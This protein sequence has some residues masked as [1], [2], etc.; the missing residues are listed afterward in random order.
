LKKR[1]PGD[2]QTR[3]DE[4]LS[5]IRDLERAIAVLP[6]EYRRVDPPD[7]DGDMKDWPRIAK[8]QSDLLVQALATR[9]TRVA[10]YML[11][12]CQSISR[13]PWLGYTAARHH[14]YT[15][16][17]G[18]TAGADG[19]EGQRVL[20]DICRWHVEEFAYL[21]SRLESVPEGDGT[22]F[23]HTSLIYVHEHAEANPHK[24]QGLAMIVAG[25]SPKLAR[26]SYTKVE[27]T[28]GDAYM[29]VADD[30][31]G[32]GIGKFP[33]ATKKIGPILA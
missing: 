10:S 19:V 7:F 13:F 22:L 15:H 18:K 17:E 26:G 9:Q 24:N 16:A 28:I 29:T 4:H 27:G 8:L 3:L 14:D 23:D 20:R 5:G 21:I 32:A 1:L 11:T 12:K 2:D 33:T 31:V 30:V 6:P 25:G